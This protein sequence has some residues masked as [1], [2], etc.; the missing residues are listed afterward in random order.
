MLAMKSTLKSVIENRWIKIIVALALFFSA[1]AEVFDNLEEL[2]V[3]AHHGVLLY[4]ILNI[5]KTLPDF[6]EG[7]EILSN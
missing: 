4:S 1:G 6:F 3:G 5:F 2:D 7:S